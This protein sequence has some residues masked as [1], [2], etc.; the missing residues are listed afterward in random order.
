MKTTQCGDTRHDLRNDVGKNEK[1]RRNGLVY[2]ET[3]LVSCPNPSV[4][5]S[6]SL[7]AAS[8]NAK[9]K[10]GSCEADP[11]VPHP[12]VFPPLYCRRARA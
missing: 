11:V 5:R 8:S 6:Y 2:K 12:T 10:A 7:F 4:T 1:N 3:S 9:E